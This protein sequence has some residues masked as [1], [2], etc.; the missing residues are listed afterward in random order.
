MR[1]V[2]N[3]S[4]RSNIA[5]YGYDLYFDAK[6]RNDLVGFRDKIVLKPNGTVLSTARV[7]KYG[8]PVGRV[9]VIF[10]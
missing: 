2:A 10:A 1:G 9:V 6:N 8:M 3:V 7:F 4:I 5:R